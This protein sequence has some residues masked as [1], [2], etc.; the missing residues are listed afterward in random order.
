[1]THVDTR[2]DVGRLEVVVPE[3]VA[4]RVRATSRLG[5]LD[6]LGERVDGAGVELDLDQTGERVLAL[7]VHV[8]LGSLQIERALP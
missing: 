6:V 3:G 1:V 4:L 7:D 5:E 8:G 2:V